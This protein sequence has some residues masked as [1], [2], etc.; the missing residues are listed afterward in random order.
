MLLVLAV[1]KHMDGEDHDDVDD[2]DHGDDYDDDHDDDHGDDIGKDVDD[3]CING[4]LFL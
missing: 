2:D 4:E 1:F 3:N